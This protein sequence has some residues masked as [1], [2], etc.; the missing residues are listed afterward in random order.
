[1]IYDQEKD[2]QL[3]AVH[4]GEVESFINERKEQQQEKYKY[5]V[6]SQSRTTKSLE[7]IQFVPME[8]TTRLAEE[9]VETNEVVVEPRQEEKR[10]IRIGSKVG[11]A[12]SSTKLG[13]RAQGKSDSKE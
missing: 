10:T 2:Y 1:M 5:E 4:R 12:G 9:D 13:F 6:P 8:E 3:S 11:P 7:I